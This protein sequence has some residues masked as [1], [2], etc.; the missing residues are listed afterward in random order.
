VDSIGLTNV[1]S[2]LNRGVDIGGETIGRPSVFHIG[3]AVNPTALDL[4]LE[5]RRFH[6]KIEAGAEYAVTQWTFD[7][8]AF[9]ACL[10]RLEP[11]GIP[12]IAGVWPFE[13]LSNAEFM[14]NEVPGLT[15]P[16]ALIERMRRAKTPEAA[17]EEG[18]AI[19][20]EIA[21]AIRP[22]VQG[23]RIGTSEGH[24]DRALAVIDG[25]A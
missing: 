10:K 24:I 9:E 18:A 17:A 21:R 20:R 7:L 15:V 25:L 23:L 13:S 19:A 6:Y 2:R 11:A 8:G 5:L 12:I 3:V 4:D 22:H 16:L 14:A 1:V